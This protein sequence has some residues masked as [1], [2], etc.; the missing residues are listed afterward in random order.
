MPK[1]KRSLLWEIERTTQEDSKYVVARRYTKNQDM[2][3]K[4]RSLGNKFQNDDY[5]GR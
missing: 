3:S 1:S 2:L 4:L 5:I